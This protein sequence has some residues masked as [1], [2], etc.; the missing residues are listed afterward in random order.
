MQLH[1]DSDLTGD[2]GKWWRT[3][4]ARRFHTHLNDIKVRHENGINTMT[5]MD[6]T[7]ELMELYKDLKSL[8]GACIQAI[9]LLSPDKDS[10]S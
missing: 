10:E 8:E 1:S 5:A 2:F 9:D 3:T 4:I 6:D 7:A